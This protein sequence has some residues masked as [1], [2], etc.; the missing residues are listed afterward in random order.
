LVKKDYKI[1]VAFFIDPMRLKALDNLAKKCGMSRSEL[2]R[3]GINKLLLEG[4][5]N[6]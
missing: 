1:M 3:I 6:G 2:I 4:G 5:I